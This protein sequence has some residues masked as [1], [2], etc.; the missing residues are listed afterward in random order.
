MCYL[1]P[2][3]INTP[4]PDVLAQGSLDRS[5]FAKV[6]MLCL[7]NLWTNNNFITVY[8]QSKRYL[9]RFK[10]LA[11]GPNCGRLAVLGFELIYF[12]PEHKKHCRDKQ[13][14]TGRSFKRSDISPV[15]RGVPHCHASEG[16][17]RKQC[18]WEIDASSQTEI[19]F[20]NIFWGN[21]SAWIMHGRYVFRNG[22]SAF[23][24][25]LNLIF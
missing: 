12:F 14:L 4:W 2:E 23:K 21:H 17:S 6:Y 8:L 18:E 24:R 7:K 15:R 3:S 5:C 9:Y 25:L 22:S 13:C 16:V 10:G 1:F 20:A 11:Q 19:Y